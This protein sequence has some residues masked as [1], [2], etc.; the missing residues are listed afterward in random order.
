[1]EW[2]LSDLRQQICSHRATLIV[3]LL[4]GVAE[5]LAANNRE[6]TKLVN[7]A[8]G[9]SVIRSK[10][11]YRAA[12]QASCGANPSPSLD[13][14]RKFGSFARQA[15]QRSCECN[16]DQGLQAVYEQ[17]EVLSVRPSATQL[18]P[19]SRA[20]WG[21]GSAAPPPAS[22]STSL[23]PLLGQSIAAQTL[24][25]ECVG[26]VGYHRLNG[27]SSEILGLAFSE[28]TP[29]NWS[30]TVGGQFWDRGQ[31]EVEQVRASLVVKAGKTSQSVRGS[32]T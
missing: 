1:M 30:C 28:A 23:E 14:K 2:V 13:C 32:G 6:P 31:A 12:H 15:L 4:P 21:L 11:P 9:E 3:S 29:P 25:L 26:A 7:L 16:V 22:D 19:L 18:C 10:R 27:V 24:Y 20:Q 17:L 5:P 8:V